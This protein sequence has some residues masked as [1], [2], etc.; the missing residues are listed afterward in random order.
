MSC[1]TEG[2]AFEIIKHEFVE[3]EPNRVEEFYECRECGQEYSDFVDK[4]EVQTLYLEEEE[5]E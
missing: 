2:H 3:D 1:Q 5:E 4:N